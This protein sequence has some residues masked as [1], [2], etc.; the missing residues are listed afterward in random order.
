MTTTLPQALA[1]RLSGRIRIQLQ[2]P[3][4]SGPGLFCWTVGDCL[5]DTSGDPAVLNGSESP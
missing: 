5:T 4:S 2:S 3:G 1:S